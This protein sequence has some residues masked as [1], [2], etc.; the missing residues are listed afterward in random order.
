MRSTCC[1]EIF[2][3][4]LTTVVSSL[5][6]TFTCTQHVDASESARRVG[7]SATASTCYTLISSVQIVQKQQG[8]LGAV[9]GP[10]AARVLGDG[11]PPSPLAWVHGEGTAPASRQL[12][13]LGERGLGQSPG[14]WTIFLCFKVSRQL[15]LLRLEEPQ[16]AARR[17]MSTPMG[18]SNYMSSGLST[19]ARGF[20]PY[21]PLSSR[22]L[23][24]C[25]PVYNNQHDPE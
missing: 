24:H 19:V 20:S 9:W 1:G 14:R 13:D 23:A 4:T 21:D 8:D 16:M 11:A 22:R 3:Y 18:A 6:W 15:M 7:P 17:V 25:L 2:S 5:P 12:G 10:I